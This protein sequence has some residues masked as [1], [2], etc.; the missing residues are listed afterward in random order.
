MG[1][2]DSKVEMKYPKELRG[3][4]KMLQQR[5]TEATPSFPQRQVAGPSELEQL[6]GQLT[7]S[8]LTAAPSEAYSTALSEA[9]KTATTPVD[10]ANMPEY[11]ALLNRIGAYGQSEAN[12]LQ[13]GNILT[14]NPSWRSTAGRDVLGRSVTETQERMMAAAVPFLQQARAEKAQAVEQLGQL[15]Q[16][17]QART[18]SQIATGSQVGQMLRAIEQAKLE[19]EYQNLMDPLRFRYETQPGIAGTAAGVPFAKT[20]QPSQYEKWVLGLGSIAGG[21]QGLFG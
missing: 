16:M 6:A 21:I 19:A 4:M 7:Q 17:G 11:Q 18:L 12:R 3:I 5:A 8:Y 1:F 14:G 13:R 10:V 20:E 15:E 2:F 9:T